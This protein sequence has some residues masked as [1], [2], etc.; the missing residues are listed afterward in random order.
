MSAHIGGNYRVFRR[1]ARSF[2]EFAKASKTHVKGGLTLADAR[3]MC[4]EFNDNRNDQQVRAGTKFEFER[5]I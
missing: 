2:E 5:E 1:S 4:A 3:A